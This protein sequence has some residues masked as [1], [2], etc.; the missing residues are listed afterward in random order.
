MLTIGFSLIIGLYSVDNIKKG[1]N[2]SIIFQ[3]G[4]VNILAKVLI[5]FG[6][7]HDNFIPFK[8]GHKTERGYFNCTKRM[9]DNIS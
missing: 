8:F 7:L 4:S 3:V 1:Q 2:H 5:I 9:V 6:I